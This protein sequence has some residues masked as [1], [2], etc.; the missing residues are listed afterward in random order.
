MKKTILIIIAA[1]LLPSGAVFGDENT[2]QKQFEINPNSAKIEEISIPADELEALVAK[3]REAQEEAVS[4]SRGG[5]AGAVIDIASNIVNLVDKTFKIIAKG[6]PVVNINT[7]YANAVPSNI[8][9]WTQLQNWAGPRIRRYS[10]SVS[11]LY[12]M[13]VVKVVYQVHYNYGGNFKGRGRFLT[14]VTIEPI[15]VY[16]LWGFNLDMTAEVPDSTIA[17]VGTTEN[18]IASMQVQLKWRVHSII[19]DVQNKDIYYIRGDGYFKQIG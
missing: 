8:K 6:Q 17:N 18:P 14:G 11:N 13:D 7:N 1:M 9:H 16:T 3:D 15:S 5:G 19:S 10:F 2:D 4:V 12:G